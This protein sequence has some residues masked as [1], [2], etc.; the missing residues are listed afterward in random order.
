VIDVVRGEQLVNR[1]PICTI[2]DLVELLL[3]KLLVFFRAHQTPVTSA[4]V[5]C[6]PVSA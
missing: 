5:V 6:E 3:H 2:P 4:E 1:G